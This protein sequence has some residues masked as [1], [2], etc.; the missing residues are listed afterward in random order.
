MGKPKYGELSRLALGHLAGTGTPLRHQ[1]TAL[2]ALSGCSITKS[3]PSML[4]GSVRKTFNFQSA[5]PY[6]RSRKVP[7]D[8]DRQPSGLVTPPVTQQGRQSTPQPPA[9]GKPPLTTIK[10]GSADVGRAPVQSL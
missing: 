9:R 3:T 2:A 8:S 6:P 10:L 1:V 5:N 7:S 4:F